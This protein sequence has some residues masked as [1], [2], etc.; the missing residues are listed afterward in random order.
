MS[1]QSSTDVY[2]TAEIWH[3]VNPVQAYCIAITTWLLRPRVRARPVG[4]FA[5]PTLAFQLSAVLARIIAE[6]ASALA[7]ALAR[8]T[9]HTVPFALVHWP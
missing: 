1:K 2:L 3:F 9:L 7:L 6:R 4:T 5:V 8:A